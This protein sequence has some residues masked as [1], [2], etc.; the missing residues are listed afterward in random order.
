MNKSDQLK[1]EAANRAVEFVKDEMTLGLGSGSTAEFAV[2]KI[3]QLYKNGSLKRIRGIPSSVKT[4]K[5]AR[6]L[7]IP[8]T[9]FS[10]YSGID[11]TIDGADEV[12]RKFNLI[13][14]GG[15]A[16]LREKIL[17]Q[18]SKQV[19]II[20][21]ESKLSPKLG[22]NWPVPVEVLPFGWENEARYLESL[23]AK[24]NLRQNSNNKIY[25]TDQKNYILDA[26]FGIIKSP[27]SLN[28]KLSLRAGIIE[29]GLFVDMATDIIAAGKDGIRHLKKQKPQ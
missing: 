28:Q 13:K 27:E 18:A 6:S 14:G 22:T 23:K 7:E 29:H 5:L 25:L 2:R 24:I 9:D 11:L 26:D 20:V 16:L 15:G 12:D 8:L 1:R 4:A 21:D 17:I 10:E 3:G 19:I